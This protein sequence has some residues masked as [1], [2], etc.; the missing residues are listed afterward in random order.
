[1]DLNKLRTQ[2]FEKTGI[3]IDTNDPV[4]ALV[5][6]NEAVLS[7]CILQQVAGLQQSADKLKEQTRLLVEAG[8]RT[9][10]LLLQMGK[11]VDDPLPAPAHAPKQT[12]FTR[13]QMPILAGASALLSALLVIAGQAIFSPSRPAQPAPA[14][15]Q[16]P[17]QSLT[18]EQ[19]Q[20]IQTGE[21]YAK[22]W[23][24]LDAKTQARI[25]ALMQ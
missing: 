10:S 19:L 21:K 23:P 17:A 14:V 4:F 1:M 20:M 2:V 11:P 22:V 5:A 24:K 9:R 6:L 7:E 12:T 15:V 8:D 18:P 25:Q 13:F 3:R 16:S